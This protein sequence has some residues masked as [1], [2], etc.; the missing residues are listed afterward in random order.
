M[1][2]KFKRYSKNIYITQNKAIMKV[3]YTE[4]KTQNMSMAVDKRAYGRNHYW[5]WKIKGWTI[6]G[7]IVIPRDIKMAEKKRGIR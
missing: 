1:T 2:K 3:K 7:R 5:K 4:N 6:W